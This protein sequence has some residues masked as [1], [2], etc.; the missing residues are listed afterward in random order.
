MAQLLHCHI[1]NEDSG[2]RQDAH[3]I[4]DLIGNPGNLDRI[5]NPPSL[6]FGK[7]TVRLFAC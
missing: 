1:V 4:S 2:D 3:V 7:N 5:G 6:K